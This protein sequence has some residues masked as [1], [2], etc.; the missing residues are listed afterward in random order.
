MPGINRRK[1][2][3]QIKSYIPKLDITTLFMMGGKKERKEG[4]KEKQANAYQKRHN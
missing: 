3:K 4:R 1:E 2:S